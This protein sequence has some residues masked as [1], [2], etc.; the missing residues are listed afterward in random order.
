MRDTAVTRA[1]TQAT[2][3]SDGYWTDGVHARGQVRRRGNGLVESF[4]I[5]KHPCKQRKPRVGPVR[6]AV[7]D[8]G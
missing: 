6:R 3:R 2:Q 4:W 8:G 1:V 5:D 7:T